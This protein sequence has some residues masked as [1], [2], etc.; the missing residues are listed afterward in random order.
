M[1][2]IQEWKNL[3]DS[4]FLSGIVE[5]RRV[6]HAGVKVFSRFEYEAKEN[7]WPRV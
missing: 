1:N 7:G 6:T 3:Q 2:P 5:G 4:S